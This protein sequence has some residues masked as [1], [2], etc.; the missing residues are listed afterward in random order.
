MRIFF[1]ALQ[2]N[3]SMQIHLKLS[4]ILVCI[5]LLFRQTNQKSQPK[6]FFLLSKDILTLQKMYF[7]Y[8]LNNKETNRTSTV[9]FGLLDA[10]ALTS[11]V[12]TNEPLQ[13][14]KY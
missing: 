4:I 13:H 1:K 2:Y 12:S 6:Y 3:D 5:L 14:C 11:T 7:H 8:F 9:T 10:F